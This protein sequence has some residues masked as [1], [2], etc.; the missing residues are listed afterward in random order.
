M[1]TWEAVL[2]SY[3]L[4]KCDTL[5]LDQLS[6]SLVQLTPSMTTIQVNLPCLIKKCSP[7]KTKQ[8]EFPDLPMKFQIVHKKCKLLYYIIIILLLH[9]NDIS[10]LETNHLIPL[11]IIL[12]S[13]FSL[14][15]TITNVFSLLFK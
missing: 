12:V 7:S 14:S 10:L 8:V 2:P 1:A 15:K 5:G 6:L 9:Y 3:Q 13:R 11:S 4:C